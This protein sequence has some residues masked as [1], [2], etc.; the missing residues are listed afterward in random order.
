MRKRG[1]P[2]VSQRDDKERLKLKIQK[3]IYAF[4]LLLLLIAVFGSCVAFI[5]RSESRKRDD[6]R[7]EMKMD[8]LRKTLKALETDYSDAMTRYLDKFTAMTEMTT[9]MLRE[10]MSDDRYE[11]PESFEDGFVVQLRNGKLVYPKGEEIIP[12]LTAELVESE[13]SGYLMEIFSDEEIDT[14]HIINSR[15]IDGNWYF[16]EITSYNEALEAVF[17]TIRMLETIREIESSYGWRLI[18]VT[19]PSSKDLQVD[20]DNEP[21]DFLIAPDELDVEAMPEDIGITNKLLSEKPE[22]IDYEG[23]NYKSIFKKITFGDAAFE[24]IVLIPV[25]KIDL[26]MTSGVLLFTILTF[27]TA[28]SIILWLYWYQTYVRDNELFPDQVTS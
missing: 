3:P 22:Y 14:K 20:Q 28:I 2:V 11:G 25:E 10:Y 7:N 27:I 26:Y 5:T 1:C 6:Q 19:N 18:F 4:L 23:S 8:G 13:I 17:N 15:N 12:N 9:L 21:I 16:I 24:M